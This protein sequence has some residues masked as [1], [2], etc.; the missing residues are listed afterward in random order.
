MRALVERVAS[1]SVTVDDE[2]AGRIDRGLLVYLG[3]AK[4]D[5]DADARFIAEKVR[6]LRIFRDEAGKMNCDVVQAG[7]AVLAISAFSLVAD[8]RKGRRPSFD[9][10]AP[11][12]AA[13]PLYERFC[14]ALRAS[15]VR[16]ETGRFRTMMQVSAVND[17][18]ITILLSS[19]P[20]A[21]D[22]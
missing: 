2:P 19:K 12:E 22:S 18:P 20:N 21:R 17:G 14:E 4:G 10:A 15:G 11:P 6:Y 9:S 13:E 7:G 16:V 8:A 3:V 1:A 5:A